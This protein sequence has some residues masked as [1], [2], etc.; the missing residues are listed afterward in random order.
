MSPV[1]KIILF[2][3]IGA[4]ICQLSFVVIKKGSQKY[5]NHY[6]T[7][8]TEI[9]YNAT[10]YDVVFLGSSRTHLSINPQ[11][12][13]SVCKVNS[14]NAGIEGAKLYEFD[15][16][17]Q[18]YLKSHPA[19]KWL[20]LTLDLHSF[21][22]T[23]KLFNY[24]LYFSYTKNDVIKEYLVENGYSLLRL[25]IFP[26]LEIT[27]Y[28]D[29]TKGTFIKGYMGRSEI[30]AGDFEYKGYLSNTNNVIKDVPPNVPP[31]FIEVSDSGIQCLNNIIKVCK[32]NNIKMIFTYAPEFNLQIEQQNLKRQEILSMISNIAKSNNIPYFRDDSLAIC[33]DPKLFANLGHLNKE[34][35][36]IYSNILGNK[37]NNV[38]YSK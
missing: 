27:D 12:I 19:P 24:S 29:D 15:M 22:M 10:P 11:V 35:G 23:P 31:Q 8:L 17:L 28:D 36:R 21:S 14:Y 5:H 33:S 3:V 30:P 18:A 6:T 26:F 20:V 32:T 1:K 2:F 7:R 25:K 38:F 37:L 16:V 34:G 13:D 4:I 9:F